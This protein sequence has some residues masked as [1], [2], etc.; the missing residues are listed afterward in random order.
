MK[1][2]RSVAFCNC[3][4]SVYIEEFSLFNWVLLPAASR[5]TGLE[6]RESG[7]NKPSSQITLMEFL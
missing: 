3:N 4:I 2:S 7:G 1:V 5:K 6:A